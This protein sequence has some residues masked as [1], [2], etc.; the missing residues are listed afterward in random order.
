MK[1][2][3]RYL[4][5]AMPVIATVALFFA[6]CTGIK[7]KEAQ[8]PQNAAFVTNTNLGSIWQKGELNNIDK[9]QSY[10]IVHEYLGSSMPQVEAF[11]TNFLKDP[12]STGIDIDKDILAFAEVNNEDPMAS[13][14][15]LSATLKSKDDFTKFLNDVADITGEKLA[16]E[17]GDL[18]YLTLDPNVLVTFNNKSVVLVAGMNGSTLKDYSKSL[19]E[20]KESESLF[21][22]DHF[23]TYW[24]NRKDMGLFLPFANWF[25][26]KGFMNSPKIKPYLKNLSDDQI[27]MF[28][29]ATYYTTT[30]FEDG[31]IVITGKSL[32][33][34]IDYTKFLGNGIDNSLM[35]FMPEKTLA[36]LSYSVN[37]PA[38]L[39]FLA[40]NKAYADEFNEPIQELGCTV[41]DIIEIFAGNFVASFYGMDKNNMP[42]CA[43]ACDIAKADLVNNFIEQAG[44]KGNNNFYDLGDGMTLFFDG[45]KLAFTTD[46]NAPSVYA[47]GGYQNGLAIV[48]DKARKGNYFY[49]DLKIQD[50]PQELLNLIGYTAG[51]SPILDQVL[52][53]FDNIEV[54][55]LAPDEACGIIKLTD[56][57]NSL[58][59][60]VGLIDNAV[61]AFAAS[62]TDDDDAIALED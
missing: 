35:A 21:S 38:C 6:S 27:A 58:A 17:E 32:G 42:L 33:T 56:N 47:Q 25:G 20:L 24:D 55:T 49:L 30:S 23:K 7:D 39:E 1:T 3:K 18:S 34:S 14:I 57:R 62:Y 46:A 59:S 54:V 26:E 43:V 29:D 8:V 2:L 40:S 11:L 9:L 37:M 13:T 45:Q 19:F 41:K 50:Y 52:A 16:I 53:L 10:S 28:K 61:M 44:L 12:S 36:T 51:E 15:T 4:T 5:L 48:A 31:S 60:I 22:N